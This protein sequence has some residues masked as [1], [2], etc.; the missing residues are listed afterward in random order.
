MIRKAVRVLITVSVII[1]C[2][3][4]FTYKELDRQQQVLRRN[5]KATEDNTDMKYILFWTTQNGDE[6]YHFSTNG[7]ELFKRCEISNCYATYNKSVLSS[8]DQYD[9]VFFSNTLNPADQPERIPEKR[10]PHQRYVFVAN[11][12]PLTIPRQRSQYLYRN[13]YNWTMTYRFD[14]DIPRRH[15]VV[16]KQKTRYKL[17]SLDYIRNK[18]KMIAWVVSNC[19]SK[20]RREKL[21]REIQ[22][23][24]PVDVYGRCGNLTCA[25]DKTCRQM[26]QDN[27]KFYISFENSHCKDYTTEKLVGVLRE[28]IIPIV[29]GGGEYASVAPPHSF[30]NVEDFS[31]VKELTD[32]LKQLAADEERYLEYFKWKTDYV[33]KLGSSTAV[34]QLCK[35]LN[36]PTQKEKVY[37]DI[38]QWWFG[39]ENS[40]CKQPQSLPPIK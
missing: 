22:K 15:G 35:M 25:K 32:H 7:S 40:K 36:D 2:L 16:E 5:L 30:I 37:E 33:V 14:S 27:Y 39:E 20:N 26:I 17:P 10:S 28:N 23:Y 8:I 21:V 6:N 3:R 12:S 4:I 19:H 18:T 11:E 29:Y 38:G 31:S 1:T 9:A 34:C 24:I 13:F